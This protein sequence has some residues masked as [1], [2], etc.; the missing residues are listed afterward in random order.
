[1][2]LALGST[3][4]CALLEGDAVVCWGRRGLGLL[5]D[6]WYMPFQAQL[7]PIPVVFP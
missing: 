3:H 2:G 4:S 6:G 5:G 1:M 7:R